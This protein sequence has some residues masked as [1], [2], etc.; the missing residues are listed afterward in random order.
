[1]SI[2]TKIGKSVKQGAKQISLKNIVKIGT[3]LLSM[4]PVVGGLAQN[5]VEGISASAEAKK[6]ARIAEMEGNL[7]KAEALH[8]Q[9][10]ALAQQS[11]AI[12]GQQAGSVI[13][14][15]TKG[16]TKEVIAQT[17]ESVKEASGQVGAS[18]IDFTIKEWFKKHWKHL[19]IVLSCIGAV[20]MIIKSKAKGMYK[21]GSS[22]SVRAHYA[23]NNARNNRWK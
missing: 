20:Y 10:N 4:I 15:F 12:V 3:P 17:S 14:A 8:A 9:S 18:V 7:A 16:A 19:L 11:G 21:K 22:S 13:N 6:Q 1:M 5:T 23:S 2:F